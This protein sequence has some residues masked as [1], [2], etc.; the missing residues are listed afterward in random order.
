MSAFARALRRGVHGWP[1]KLE[2]TKQKSVY[3]LLLTHF[4]DLCELRAAPT[5]NDYL[6]VA[7]RSLEQRQ[8]CALL[9]TSGS[10]SFDS[11]TSLFA[12][13]RALFLHLQAR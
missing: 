12:Y 4:Q 11:N 6:V 1:L 5:C 8:A 2:G 7:K 9:T 3:D 13:S 10:F